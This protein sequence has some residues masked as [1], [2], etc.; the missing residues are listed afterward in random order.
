M[1]AAM[2]GNQDGPARW[3]RAIAALWLMLAAPLAGCGGGADR[4]PVDRTAAAGRILRVASINPCVDA[5]LMHVAD[6]HQIAGIS[7]YS[8]DPRATSVPIAWASRFRATSG[9]AEEVVA[10]APDLVIAGGHVDPATIAALGR[11]DIPIVQIGVPQTVDESIEQVR[12]VARA[13]GRPAAGDALAR[14]IGDAVGQAAPAG[15]G[16]VSALIWQGGGMVPGTGTLADDLL[17]RTGYRNLSADYGLNQWDVLP[18]EPLV[19]DP[20]RLLLSVR[21][22]GRQ[23]RML[24]HPVLDDL[25][26]QIAVRDYPER[27]MRCGGPTIIDAADRLARIRRSL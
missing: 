23:D 27:L 10:L 22:T 9:T 19:A 4:V 5:I 1:G 15:G 18:L 6:P 16:A 7:H 13:I 17:T 24:G 20:P 11:M 25:R 3:R 26:R 21:A 8:Q 12:V 14:R 2:N